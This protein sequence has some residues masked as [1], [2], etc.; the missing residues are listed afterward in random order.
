MITNYFCL[1][2]LSAAVD[3]LRLDETDHEKKKTCPG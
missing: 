1:F 3:H 2:H